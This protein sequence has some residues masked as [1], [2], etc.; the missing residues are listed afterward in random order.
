MKIRV[1][2]GSAGMGGGEGTVKGRA[3]H[4]S[5]IITSKGPTLKFYQNYWMRDLRMENY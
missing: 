1:G 4:I 5:P 2:G 3:S